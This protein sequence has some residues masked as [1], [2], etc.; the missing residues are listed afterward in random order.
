M[1]LERPTATPLRIMRSITARK[2]ASLNATLT[3]WS[4]LSTM[5]A[6]QLWG[7]VSRE[8]TRSNKIVHSL[9][10][11]KIEGEQRAT[12]FLERLYVATRLQLPLHPFEFEHPAGGK[13][14]KVETDGKEPVEEEEVYSTL[15][16]YEA[17]EIPGILAVVRYTA[18]FDEVGGLNITERSYADTPEGFCSLEED[19]PQA[20]SIGVCVAVLSHIDPEYLPE[21]NQFLADSTSEV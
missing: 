7:R 12:D 19:V 18:D 17:T 15:D 5:Q 11:M 21:I 2:L 20:L 6:L 9:L 14:H 16:Y 3:H 4:G 13:C 10:L 1:T 8:P